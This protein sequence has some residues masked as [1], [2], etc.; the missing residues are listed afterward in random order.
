MPA[1]AYSLPSG[2]GSAF[3]AGTATPPPS[4]RELVSRYMVYSSLEVMRPAA[5]AARSR[6]TPRAIRQAT[7]A[8]VVV[9]GT[10]RGLTPPPPGARPRPPTGDPR[11]SLRPDH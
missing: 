3:P 10:T 7:A 4:T 9:A 5:V 11:A 1:F 6:N 2:P 8:G